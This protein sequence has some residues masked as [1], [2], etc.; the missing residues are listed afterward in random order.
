MERIVKGLV[1]VCIRYNKA[2][3]VVT[4]IPHELE[5]S[6]KKHIRTQKRNVII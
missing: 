6:H 2:T 5:H 3:V 4:C 1:G